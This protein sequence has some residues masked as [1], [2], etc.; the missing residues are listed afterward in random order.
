[1]PNPGAIPGLVLT[2]L[3]TELRKALQLEA[4]ESLAFGFTKSSGDLLKSPH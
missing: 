2:L 4:A 1:M 3:R